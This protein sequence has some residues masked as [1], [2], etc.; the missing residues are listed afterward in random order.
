MRNGQT[1]RSSSGRGPG[2]SFPRGVRPPAVPF[3]AGCTCAPTTGRRASSGPPP[4]PSGTGSIRRKSSGPARVSILACGPHEM[5]KAVA[6]LAFP[7]TSGFRC[8]S[9]AR[10]RAGSASA[11]GASRRFGTARRPGTGGSAGK[12]RSSTRGRSSG[13]AARDPR[14]LRAGGERAPQEPGDERLRHLR[15][16]SGIHAV[17][18]HLP[19]GG[20]DR[21][22]AVPPADA[23]Q[24]SR[25]D[26]GDP[27]GDAERD[28]P[29]EH[30]GRA[31]RGTRWRRGWTTPAPCTSR[32]STGARSRSTRRWRGGSPATCPRWRRSS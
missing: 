21:Q 32:T 30:R 24:R 4:R 18:R 20:G 9:K 11:G 22:G 17:L 15:V 25:A 29:A 27:R 23:G 3:R 19:A 1:S 10:W 26:R 13:D 5:L 14:P 6:E 31:V 8:P 7:S 12:V 16:R 2:T 28:G